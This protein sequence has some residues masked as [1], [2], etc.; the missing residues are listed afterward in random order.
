MREFYYLE[1]NIICIIFLTFINH[2]T[3]SKKKSSLTEKI[4]RNSVFSS[5]LLCFSDAVFG[6][7]DG[8]IFPGCIVLNHLLNMLFFISGTFAA[9]GWLFF[10]S[11]KICKKLTKKFMTL[12]CIPSLLVSLLMITNPLT[13][14][15]FTVDEN[16]FYARGPLIFIQWISI[17]Y[18]LVYATILVLNANK[19]EYNRIVR[20]TNLSYC[21]FGI[22]PIVGF[23]LQVF[24]PGMTSTTVGVALGYLFYYIK[25]LENQ[26]SEDVLTGLNNRKQMEKYVSD[27]VYRDSDSEKFVMMMD[28]NGFKNINDTFGHTTGDLALQDFAD[29]LRLA[30]RKWRGHYM[31]CRYGGDEFAV[32]GE[33]I[34]DSDLQVFA[35]LI[36]KNVEEIS[37]QKNREYKLST[38][39][40]YVIGQC[41]KLEDFT[42][43]YKEADA[44]MYEDKMRQKILRTN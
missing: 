2:K 13:S 43:M 25:S 19:K 31:L 9:M 4:F 34:E 17:I 38:S 3:T 35:D 29:A 21:Y 7:V 5:E 18:Y 40:G 20:A 26:I 44:L 33:H 22:F 42:R 8:H 15:A 14:L 1:V 39:I 6:I 27:L 30:C 28:L 37:V 10:V 32:V 36:R 12:N 16:N 24:V 11:T 41:K 23:M